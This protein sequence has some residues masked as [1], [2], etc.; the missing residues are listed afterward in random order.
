MASALTRQIS[1]HFFKRTSTGVGVWRVV[2][3]KKGALAKK[4][5][6]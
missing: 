1:R 2:M 5:E 6:K 3:M 4:T